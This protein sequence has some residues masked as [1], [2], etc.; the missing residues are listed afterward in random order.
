[1]LSGD[2]E[3]IADDDLYEYDEYESLTYIRE[4]DETCPHFDSLNQCCWIVSKRGLCSDVQEGD[5]CLYDF[6]ENDV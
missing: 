6:K 1:M 4:C 3:M 5:F 2:E